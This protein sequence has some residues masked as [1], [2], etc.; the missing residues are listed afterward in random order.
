MNEPNESG[1]P[2]YILPEQYFPPRPPEPDQDEGSDGASPSP[3]PAQ[4]STGAAGDDVPMAPAP[5]SSPLDPPADGPPPEVPQPEG[6]PSNELPPEELP[7]EEPPLV[8]HDPFAPI[9]NAPWMNRSLS[10]SARAAILARRDLEAFPAI[11]GRDP[12]HADLDAIVKRTVDYIVPIIRREQATDIV[13]EELEKRRTDRIAKARAA[14]PVLPRPVLPMAGGAAASSVLAR[15]PVPAAAAPLAAAA[16]LLT[17]NNT[18]NM[19]VDLG[20]GL[21]LSVAPDEATVRLQHRVSL[22]LPKGLKIG[23]WKDLPVAAMQDEALGGQ[24]VFLIDP[25][26]LTQAIGAEAAARVLSRPGVIG[27]APTFEAGEIGLT[28]PMEIRIGES[29]SVE[30]AAINFREATKED[31][32]K[33]CP[34]IPT[35]ERIGR[36]AKAEAERLTGLSKGPV[37]GTKMHK[38]AEKAALASVEGKLKEM[39]LVETLFEKALLDGEPGYSKKGHVKMDVF[40]IYRGDTACIIDYK[41]GG[42]TLGRDQ[43]RRYLRQ[44]GYYIS[45][46]K[47]GYRRLFIVPIPL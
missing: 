8:P 30:G 35:Y 9:R 43:M 10:P 31:I 3:Q 20:D 46:N 1:L 23:D 4:P 29:T 12:N 24:R 18:Q 38:V 39:G 26:Q 45:I 11:E 36:E 37:L 40:E 33:Y 21:R 34:N 42:A 7:P 13:Y 2:T 47:L 28:G 6:P 19:A 32:E 15:V 25:G 22:P 27:M 41:T 5:G 14:A 44:A 17:P 16:I